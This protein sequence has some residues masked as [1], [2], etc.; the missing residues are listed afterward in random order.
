VRDEL[1]L[2]PAGNPIGVRIRYTI[3]YDDGLDDLHYAPFATV[4]LNDPTGNLLTLKK[5]VSPTISGRYRSSEYQFIEDH[6]PSFLPAGFIFPESKDACFR[7][8]NEAERTAVLR[9]APQRYQIMIEPYRHRS[10]TAN[11]Y[12]LR[13][14][15][16]GALR[17]GAKEC[18]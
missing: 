6:V 7:W 17:E 16:Q 15:Y 8:S 3:A 11:G 18:R 1:L 9:S 13:T 10:E 4:H 14:F 5:A 12:A 2:G